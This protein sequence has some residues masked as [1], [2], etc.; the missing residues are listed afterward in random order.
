MASEISKY[1]ICG[2]PVHNAWSHCRSYSSFNLGSSSLGPTA[3]AP[4]WAR[5]YLAIYTS[6]VHVKLPA[7]LKLHAF[8]LPAAALVSGSFGHEIVEQQHC[9]NAYIIVTTGGA[10][11]MRN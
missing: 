1:V 7:Q 9:N 4:P 3:L 11:Q 10:S 5:K 8:G 6:T 2:W